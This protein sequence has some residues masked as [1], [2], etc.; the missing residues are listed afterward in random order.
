MDE[1]II[2]A[3]ASSRAPVRAGT[4]SPQ[5]ILVVNDETD[6]RQLNVDVLI[7]AGYEVD[8]AK[9][10]ASGWDALQ[11][12]GYDLVVTDNHM[13]RMTGIEMIAKMRSAGMAV[14]VIMATGAFPAAIIE[15]NPW[16]KPDASL[17]TPFSNDELL[18]TVK[19][20]LR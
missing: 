2:S 18:T 15:R 1:G 17:E 7:E 19:K 11:L 4:N 13:P 16:L 3:G 10:G 8:A 20:V 5:R 6:A 14:P 9:D 12:N